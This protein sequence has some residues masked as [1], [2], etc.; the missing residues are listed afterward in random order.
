M[1]SKNKHLKIQIPTPSLPEE[2]NNINFSFRYYDTT[3]NSYCIS[4]WDEEK[5][6]KTLG[7]LQD[8][9]NKTYNELNRGSNVYHFHPVD[10]A[11]TIKQGGFPD[12]RANNLEPF[13][14]ALLGING[15]KA[16]VY[17]ALSQNTFYIVWFDINHEI[18]PT[19]KKHT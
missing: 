15:K 14:F 3:N 9:S 4:T 6:A 16:R 7:R 12:S 1:V 11:Q 18:W 8:I 19:L 5:I 2:K 10:W 13:Q 17:G